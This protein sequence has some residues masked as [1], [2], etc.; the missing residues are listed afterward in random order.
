MLARGVIAQL[1]SRSRPFV[2][3]V[4]IRYLPNLGVLVL[5]DEV[6]LITLKLRGAEPVQNLQSTAVAAKETY[7]D[8]APL[9][10]TRSM[11][12]NSKRSSVR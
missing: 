12:R 4:W 10:A 3:A 8:S 1:T 11:P 7:R 2:T 6:A 5:D 9:P